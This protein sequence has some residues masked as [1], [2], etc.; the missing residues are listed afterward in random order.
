MTTATIETPAAS[1]T[2]TPQRYRWSVEEKNALVTEFEA[3]KGDS[4]ARK[5]VLAKFSALTGAQPQSVQA[6]YYAVKSK[7][8]QPVGQPRGTRSATP[9]APKASVIETLEAR[10][11]K[12]QERIAADR[13]AAKALATRIREAKAAAK[14]KEREAAKARKAEI[15]ATEAAIA[16]AQAKLAALAG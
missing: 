11:A 10:L 1:A 15:E 14:V 5:A 9:A 7:A 16:A 3:A 12:R 6:T 2:T 8:G 13:E 4:E